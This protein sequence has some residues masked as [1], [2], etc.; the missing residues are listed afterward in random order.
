[1][2]QLNFYGLIVVIVLPLF[3]VV[4]VVFSVIRKQRI[5][6]WDQ[7]H[8]IN[9]KDLELSE[10]SVEFTRIEDE[11]NGLLKNHNVLLKKNNSLLIKHNNLF[12]RTKKQRYTD[13]DASQLEE[14]NRLL[15]EDS[16]TNAME[17]CNPNHNLLKH[18]HARIDEYTVEVR[19]LKNNDPWL[20]KYKDL[21]I[22]TTQHI[23]RL[24]A[25]NCRLSRES[26]ASFGGKQRHIDGQLIRQLSEERAKNNQLREHLAVLKDKCHNVIS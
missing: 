25:E 4:W 16:L 24:E 21:S 22:K 23:N 20:K 17:N 11:Y 6:I 2:Y 15:R 13:Y 5:T 12:E 26:D 9:K 3:Y 18:L 1:M 8:S 10:I 7:Y 14:E 19:N